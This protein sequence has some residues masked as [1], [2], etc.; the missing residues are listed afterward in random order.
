M[1]EPSS[2]VKTFTDIDKCKEETICY[3]VNPDGTLTDLKGNIDIGQVD[4]L[5]KVL[6]A[7]RCIRHWHDAMKD[8]SGMVVSAEAVRNLWVAV[9]DHDREIKYGQK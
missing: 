1:T 2:P 5:H 7:A 6:E 8:N 4:A 9:A 3:R